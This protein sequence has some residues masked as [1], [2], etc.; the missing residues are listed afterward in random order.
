MEWIDREAELRRAWEAQ[1]RI[2]GR[3]WEEVS[4]AVRFGWEA[5]HRPEFRGKRWDQVRDDLRDHWTRRE[6]ASEE[7]SWDVV[8]D[9]IEFGWRQGGGA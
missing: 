9:A 4:L 2:P 8:A 6:E 3:Q 7:E 5:A 1:Q